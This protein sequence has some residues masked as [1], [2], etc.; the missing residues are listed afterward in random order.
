MSD[1]GSRS[2]I[3][4]RLSDSL[5]G[6]GRKKRQE[7]D[8]GLPPNF[9]STPPAFDGHTQPTDALAQS[10]EPQVGDLHAPTR[11]I[12]GRLS[13]AFS[14]IKGQ[15]RNA[16]L[17]GIT[18]S[19]SNKNV[20]WSKAASWA[21]KAIQNRGAALY[22]KMATAALCA[23]FLA[24]IAALFVENWI[25]E[26]TP[27]R[28]SLGSGGNRNSYNPDEYSVIWM[29]NLFNSKG[30]LPGEEDNSQKDQGGVPVRTSLPFNLIGTLILRDEIRS[31]ATIEDKSANQVYPVRQ[32]DEIPSKAK[33]IKVEANKVTFINTGTGRREFIDIPEDPNAQK[34]ISVLPRTAPAKAG[35]KV[36]K[37]SETQFQIPTTAVQAALSNFN[38]VLT[39]ARAVPNFENGAP[40]GYKLFQIVPNSIYAQLGLQ[41]GDTVCGMNGES[42]NDPA[43]A[44]E[45]LG[46]LKSG[47]SHLELCVKRNGQTKNMTYD[48]K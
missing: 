9:P 24:D 3:W 31:L 20:D 5:K 11:G 43:K 8:L 25:P 26:P 40:A 33:I 36:E 47:A 37:V 30:L 42:I 29:R 4:K 14:Q 32:D 7:D 35:G 17:S 28:L 16:S 45:M 48:I 44:F 27:V 12:G 38:E 13:G 22:G 39:Q 21:Q 1:S 10:D 46:A 19:I 18:T 2:S 23:W 41:N 6:L 15:V 34:P